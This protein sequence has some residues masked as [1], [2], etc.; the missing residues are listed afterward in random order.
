MF[1]TSSGFTRSPTPQ[2]VAIESL[3]P[4]H[5]WKWISNRLNV[6]CLH[7]AALIQARFTQSR[8]GG[9]RPLFSA[10][11]TCSSAVRQARGALLLPFPPSGPKRGIMR[12]GEKTEKGGGSRAEAEGRA[13]VK[14]RSQSSQRRNTGRAC[15]GEKPLL[16]PVANM[17]R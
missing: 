13:A 5:E 3:P 16:R 10:G 4:L 17:K 11:P 1:R 15:S 8:Q 12:R 7:L 2:D 14:Y 6:F 9:A